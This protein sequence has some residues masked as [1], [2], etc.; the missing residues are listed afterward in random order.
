MTHPRCAFGASPSTGRR[1]R[2]G[3]AS[4]AAA[5]WLLAL[6]LVMPAT[7]SEFIVGADVSTLAEVE[8]QGGK[9]SDAE[10][11]PGDPL[12]IL[13]DHGVNWARLRLWHTPVNAADVVEKGRV[14]SRRGDPVGGGNNDLAV[15]L[16]LAK[17]ARADGLKVLLDIH[18]SD[19]WADPGKQ[20]K[21]AA[22]KDLQGQALQEAVHRY[23]AEV[24]RALREAGAPPD[25]VQ[26]GNETNGG[27]LWPDGKT[28]H[29]TP[30][31][32]IGGDAAFAALLRAGIGAVREH[33]RI[34]GARLPVVLHLADAHDNA[35]FRRVFDMAQRERLDYDVIGLSYYPYH[36]GPK[37]A[38]QANL[39]D[40]AQRYRKPLLLV[41][42][43]WGY[44]LDNADATPNIFNAEAA[45]KGGYPASVAGQAAFLR[46]T[47]AMLSAVPGGLGLGL[48]YW[49]P[50]W[51]AVPGAGWRSGEG[52]GW[53]NQALF[54]ARGRALPSMKALR[55]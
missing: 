8:R 27:M 46:D 55:R 49:E 26:I 18:Y 16:A 21:P 43:A 50:A 12:R 47:I 34:T 36:H 48:V 13:R 23:T 22:W 30:G 29:E 14:L 7:A 24:L 1:Q 25:M 33:D 28:W 52:N 5:A 11:R 42:V 10:G 31:E 17:R 51:I 41:E 35:L 19:F 3:R 39:A 32:K 2:P 37:A 4:S 15:T 9:F 38:V 40:L 45:A 44:T 53:D 54:D 6:A 20:T